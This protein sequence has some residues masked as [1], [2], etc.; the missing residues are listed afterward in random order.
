M[1]KWVNQFTCP[2]FMIVPR[3][4][5]LVGI[6]FKNTISRILHFYTRNVDAENSAFS[7][8]NCTATEKN[9]T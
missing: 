2:G 8:Q 6:T 1:S 5:T 9:V 7:R 4:E 3:K